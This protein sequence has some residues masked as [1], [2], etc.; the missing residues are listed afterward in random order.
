MAPT[1]AHAT[2]VNHQH[3]PVPIHGEDAALA[4]LSSARDHSSG[5]GATLDPANDQ[6]VD[7]RGPHAEGVLRDDNLGGLPAKQGLYNPDEEKDACGCVRTFLPLGL[8]CD[9]PADPAPCPLVSQ[10]RLRLPHQGQAVAQGASSSSSSSL[11]D[12]LPLPRQSL[13][14][15]IL[16]TQIVSDARNLLCAFLSMARSSRPARR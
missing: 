16:F 3:H 8:S 13:T 10:C 15:S 4:R 2:P 11:N 7:D 5:S 14:L 1:L 12:E 9:P 6:A